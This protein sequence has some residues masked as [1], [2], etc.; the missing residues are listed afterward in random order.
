MSRWQVLATVT[1]IMFGAHNLFVK[2]AAGRLPDAWGAFILEAAAALGVLIFL[3][4]L[5]LLGKMPPWP[6]DR[7]AMA[8]VVCGGLFIA[9]GSI[10]YFM[11]FRLG[12]P[13]SGAVPWV[14]TGWVVVVVFF[15]LIF[16]HEALQLR[17]AAGLASAVLAIWLL[18]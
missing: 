3:A 13:L 17:H 12:A 11:V 16:E 14:L 2:R 8:M 18:R 5:A 7:A 10:L 6:G 1:A 9:A 4:A 15:G